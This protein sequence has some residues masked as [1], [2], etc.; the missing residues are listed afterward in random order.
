MFA[1]V[2]A[3]R[4]G[5]DITKGGT[6]MPISLLIVGKMAIARRDW[7]KCVY[8]YDGSYHFPKIE[9][10]FLQKE[11]EEYFKPC[12]LTTG[13]SEGTGKIQNFCVAVVWF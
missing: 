13:S 12:E 1:T 4:D 2:Y 6:V 8:R 5:N 9:A 11:G 3:L 7:Y 10:N